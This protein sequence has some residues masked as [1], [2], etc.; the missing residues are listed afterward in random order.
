MRILNL[1]R[2]NA[3]SNRSDPEDASDKSEHKTTRAH[4]PLPHDPFG[5]KQALIDTGLTSLGFRSDLH[6]A[7][8]GRIVIL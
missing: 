6:D 3:A 5:S 8:H 1:L 7:I 2:E 4:I